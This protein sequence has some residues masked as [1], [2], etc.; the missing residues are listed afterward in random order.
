M[1]DRP[2]KVTI[3]LEDGRQFEVELMELYRRELQEPQNAYDPDQD[4][5]WF[6]V[7]LITGTLHINS[8]DSA[9]IDLVGG[10]FKEDTINGSK[11][12]EIIEWKIS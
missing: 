9:M 11:E 10:F 7:P 5:Y 4:S 8:K 1:K 3:K 12:T 6:I 2:T